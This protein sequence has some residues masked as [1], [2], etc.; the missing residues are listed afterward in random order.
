MTP[1]PAFRDRTDAGLRLGRYAAEHLSHADRRTRPLVLGLPRGGVKV[2][3]EVARTVEAD[4]DVV[5]ARKITAPG[6]PELG[7]G[8]VTVSG[9]VFWH[10]ELLRRLVLTEDDLAEQVVAERAEAGRRLHRYRGD[11]TLPPLDQRT[12]LVVDD[13]LATGSTAIAALREVRLLKP[14]KLIL[15]VPVGARATIDVVR[16]EADELW[17]LE[18]PERFTAV[19]AWYGDFPQLTDDQVEQILASA[20]AVD[21]S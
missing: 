17:A 14:R 12:V 16:D 6:D 20:G 2:A 11:R 9:P 7:L 19:S 15:A 8:A 1:R 3:A 5:V 10:D 13:G 4:L 21:V 18:C